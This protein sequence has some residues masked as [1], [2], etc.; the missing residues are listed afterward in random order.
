MHNDSGRGG[1]GHV[2]KLKVP[3]K[4]VVFQGNDFNEWIYSPEALR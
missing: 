2:L 1:V 3:A 4:D